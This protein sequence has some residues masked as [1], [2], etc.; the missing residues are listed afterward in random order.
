MTDERWHQIMD[1]DDVKLTPEEF[2]EGW[3]F[4]PEM[5]GLLADSSDHHGDCF[6]S[7]RTKNCKIHKTKLTT[8]PAL[9]I[10]YCKECGEGHF[11]PITL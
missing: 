7:L 5:D 8:H 3:H 6:C 9:G 11:E 4:C 1:G 10:D 2:S